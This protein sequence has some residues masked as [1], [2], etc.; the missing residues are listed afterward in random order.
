MLMRRKWLWTEPNS[1]ISSAASLNA[2]NSWVSRPQHAWSVNLG[3]ENLI[4]S[5]DKMQWTHVKKRGSCRKISPIGQ[6]P[7]SNAGRCLVSWWFNRDI[8]DIITDL[9]DIQTRKSLQTREG[10]GKELHTE[11]LKLVIRQRPFFWKYATTGCLHSLLEL[12]HDVRGHQLTITN[13]LLISFRTLFTFLGISLVPSTLD[14][15]FPF[16]MSQKPRF[17]LDSDITKLCGEN[18]MVYARL[19]VPTWTRVR[20][21]NYSRHNFI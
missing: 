5:D 18:L 6:Y 9:K 2:W 4:L 10:F 17:W 16:K 19:T 21:Q 20:Y 14:D 12:F 15:S 1:T 3:L 13:L 8:S 7:K 11:M